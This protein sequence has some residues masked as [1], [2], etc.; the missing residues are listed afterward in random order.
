ML[1]V[2]KGGGNELSDRNSRE[3]LQIA[4]FERGS[5]ISQQ[6][7]TNMMAIIKEKKRVQR[8]NESSEQRVKRLCGPHFALVHRQM[9]TNFVQILI[10][11]CAFTFT[12]VK[13]TV[14]K[15]QHNIFA[16]PPFPVLF[17]DKLTA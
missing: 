4:C 5:T 1:I 12:H 8:K 7:N 15:R 13:Y 3:S 14:E 16:L 10:N 6:H 9:N 2:V 17:F 11:L